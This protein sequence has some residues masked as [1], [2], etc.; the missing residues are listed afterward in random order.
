VGA[1]A[2]RT[3][4]KRCEWRELKEDAKGQDVDVDSMSLDG[5]LKKVTNSEMEGN[6]ERRDE[7]QKKSP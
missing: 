1:S 4:S 5:E 2:N 3:A 6:S 7:S